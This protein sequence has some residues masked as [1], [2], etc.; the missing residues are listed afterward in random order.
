MREPMFER[1]GPLPLWGPG[2][3]SIGMNL[4]NSE[5][6]MEDKEPRSL[7][8]PWER[9]FLADLLDQVGHRLHDPSRPI[10]EALDQLA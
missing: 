6:S 3:D 7:S 2:I 1:P 4:T 5:A 8:I 9:L 10:G